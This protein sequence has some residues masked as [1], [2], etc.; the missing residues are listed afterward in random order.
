MLRIESNAS[1]AFPP[2]EAQQR[3][4]DDDGEDDRCVEPQA[5]HQL[6]EADAIST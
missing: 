4:E 1:S 3:V 5:Q 6:G 2:Q